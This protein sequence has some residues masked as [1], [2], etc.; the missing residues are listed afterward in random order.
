MRNIIIIKI[1]PSEY[2][3]NANIDTPNA[4]EVIFKDFFKS[5]LKRFFFITAELLETER[6]NV[7]LLYLVHL[8]KQQYVL[9]FIQI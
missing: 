1:Q 9:L 6:S 2:P 7:T 3:P 4:I 8:S 5:C